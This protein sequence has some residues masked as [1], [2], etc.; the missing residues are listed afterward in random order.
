MKIKVR[1]TDSELFTWYDKLITTR[2]DAVCIYVHPGVVSN[3]VSFT[4]PLCISQ[5]EVYCL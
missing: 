5:L 4:R 1:Y 3:I 2:R